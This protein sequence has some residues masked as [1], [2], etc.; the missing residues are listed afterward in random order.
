MAGHVRHAAGDPIVRETAQRAFDQFG[1]LHG[2]ADARA[3]AESAWWWCK[4]YLTFVHHEFIIRQR[5]GEAGHLQGLIS[6]EVLVR[7]DKPEG[8]CAIFSEC[9]G[10]FLTS[11]GVPFEFV[12]VAANPN[13]PGIFSHVFVYAVMPD[14]QR[15]P[16]DA[17]HGKYPGWQVPSAHV[18]RRQV[19]PVTARPW[20]ITARDSM[21]C[22]ITAWLRPV[23]IRYPVKPGVRT[24]LRMWRPLPRLRTGP[25]SLRKWERWVLIFSRSRRFNRAR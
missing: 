17:S 12:T 5:L 3:I 23:S 15:L 2:A 4:V 24:N 13:E 7:M 10:A 9:L 14:G 11:F 8:D 25:A 1:K 22:T 21:A 20:P 6:P 16:L 18:S 19:W